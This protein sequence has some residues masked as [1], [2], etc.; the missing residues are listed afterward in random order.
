MLLIRNGL[1]YT[2][3]SDEPVHADLLI[4]EGKIHMVA[5][6]FTTQLRLALPG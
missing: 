4:K 3:E 2:M 6:P 5:A 1:L